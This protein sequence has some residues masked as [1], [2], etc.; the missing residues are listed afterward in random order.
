MD[1][2]CCCCGYALN[3][4]GEYQGYARLIC[5]KCGFE[6]FAALDANNQVAPGVYEED[7]DY[8]ADLAIADN[9]KSLIQWSHEHAIDYI[10]KEFPRG[11]RILDVGCFNGFFVRVLVDQGYDAVGV[12]FNKKAI[13]YGIKHYGL[14]Q[15]LRVGGVND[16]VRDTYDVVVLFEVLEHLESFENLLDDLVARLRPGGALIVSVPNACMSWRPPLDFPPHHLSRFTPVAIKSLLQNSGLR[17]D[18]HLEQASLFDFV[19][20]FSGLAFRSSGKSMRG[21]SFRARPVVDV[22][23]RAAN[24]S[25]SFL[26]RCSYPLDWALGKMGFRYISQV[27]IARKAG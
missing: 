4:F 20:N 14:H 21:G 9:Y 19:R 16:G 2:Q 26:K 25:R 8:D 13:D 3:R 7:S 22:L 6:H 1:K 10:A 12:D 23:R 27:V 15:R 11:S 5:E 17:V 18:T 24:F